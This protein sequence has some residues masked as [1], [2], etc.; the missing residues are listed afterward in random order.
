[1]PAGTRLITLFGDIT[2]I[3]FA[4]GADA[5]IVGRDTSSVYPP[6][7]VD[8]IPNLG[9]A[10]ALNAEAILA[11]EPTIVIGNSFAGPENVLDQLRAAGVTVVK[12][13]TP[14]GLDAP[15]IKLRL[16][17]ETLGIPLR[18][19]AL[20]SDVERRTAEALAAAASD[21]SSAEKPKVLFVYL[22]RGGIQLVTGEG[23]EA[24]TIIE[25]AGGVDAGAAAGLVGWVPL[26]PEALVAADPDAYL[27]MTLSYEMLGGM[28]GLLAIPG[29]AETRAGRERRVIVMDDIYLLGFGLRLPE[30]IRD[31]HESIAEI[32]PASP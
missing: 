19:E 18:A 30:A 12:F 10:G 29:M 27:V 20:A 14:K 9:F 25:A 21:S 22:R 26:T 13:E 24:Q 1:M 6:G 15:G 8:R 32:P 5:Y 4:L 16:V 28:E 3:V 11:L 23:N 17:G 7:A 2:E 31:L